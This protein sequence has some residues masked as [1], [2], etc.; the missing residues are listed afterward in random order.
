METG[1]QQKN[2]IKPKTDSLYDEQT[3]KIVATLTPSSLFLPR[4]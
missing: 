1:K 2:Q 3:W 4:L